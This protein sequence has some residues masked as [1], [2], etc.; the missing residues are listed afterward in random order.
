MEQ[1]KALERGGGRQKYPVALRE[2]VVKIVL[3]IREET[4]EKRRRRAPTQRSYGDMCI[5]ADRGRRK[6]ASARLVEG[7]GPGLDATPRGMRRAPRS[8]PRL[9]ASLGCAD[10]R[11]S[12]TGAST[13]ILPVESFLRTQTRRAPY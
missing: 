13:V 11:D 10:D 5:S 7:I 4:G 12:R 3:E 8:R 2:R 1:G 6:D 9:W